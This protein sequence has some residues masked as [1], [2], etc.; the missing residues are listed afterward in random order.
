MK[1]INYAQKDIERQN[2]LDVL[3]TPHTVAQLA[4]LLNFPNMTIRADVKQLERDGF[5][6]QDG[7]VGNAMQYK[8]VVDTYE[9]NIV[10]NDKKLPTLPYARVIE[11]R[12]VPRVPY[13]T[14]RVNI[15]CTLEMI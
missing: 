5:V 1:K 11:E 6:V 8:T 4:N 3:A 15:G 14:K 9:R 2:I 7:F 13:S 12:H 10:H